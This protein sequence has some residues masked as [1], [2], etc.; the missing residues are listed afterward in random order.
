MNKITINGVSISAGRSITIV[1]GKILIDAKDCSIDDK[2]IDIVVT[3][4]VENITADTCGSIAINGNNGTIKTVSGDVTVHG[5][6]SGSV[7]TVSGE[8]HAKEIHGSVSTISGD[9]FK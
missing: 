5:S 6:V 8:V 1:N 2:N 9:I 4:N 7:S 3:G